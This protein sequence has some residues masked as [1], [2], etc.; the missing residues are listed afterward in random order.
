MWK[1]CRATSA[2]GCA[3]A[4]WASCSRASTCWRAP[5]RKRTSSCRC[6]TA[7]TAPACAALPRRQKALQSVG[8]GGWEHHT[9]AELSGGQQQ[10]VAIA[11][12]IVTE[13]AVVLADEPTG[14]LDTQ[15]SHEIM[16]LLLALNRDHGITV[17]M[18]THEPDMAAYARRMVH[19]R[20]R[21]HRQG[22]GQRHPTTVAPATDRRPRRLMLYSVF[23]LALRSVQRNMLRSFLT[24]LGIVI[25]VSAVITM[26]T[27][28]N[29]ATQA[30]KTQISSLG[31]NLLLVSPGQRRRRRWRRRGA[32]V[33]RGRRRGH[34]PRRS[35][36]WPRWRR[37]AVPASPWW[38][39]AATG[40]PASPAA[41]TP[42]S[43]PAT[44]S[45]PGRCL[46]RRRTAAGAAVCIV[47][48]TVRREIFGGT[49]GSTGLG[50][51]LRIKQFSCEVI[52]ILAAKGQG[53]MGDQDDTVVVPLHTCSAASPA[54][55]KVSTL[56]VSM[57]EG[58]D[59]TAEGQ[60]APAAARAAQAGRRRRRQLQHLRHPAT[61]RDPVQ[62]HG[63]ADHAAGRGGRG[64]PAGGRHRHHEHHAGQRDR[65]HARDRPAPGRG[66]AGRRGAAA[67]PDRSGG[68]V[69]AGRRGGHRSSPPARPMGRL[70]RWPCPMS[71]TR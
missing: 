23:M 5:R 3:G 71:S 4:T 13:P 16:G 25:G 56:S 66:R 34:R 37:R 45:W 42:G 59:S 11:R 54:A 67:V 29:G 39:T 9:P 63:R 70:A 64:E 47:G 6:C 57:E 32:A 58:S 55:R 12:A 38:P 2:R 49:A 14:N 27:L 68:A 30:I 40:P 69:G 22:R 21:A 15:R 24:I 33:H 48:E 65:A 20:R 52:G 1:R 60:P 7:A 51:Q 46:R 17:L 35:A 8:L 19:L 28:G 43:S 18:V 50:E 10:R 44:G 36:A 41:P 53:G 31:T 61:G 26:V 62:H